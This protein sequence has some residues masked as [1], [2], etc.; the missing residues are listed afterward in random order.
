MPDDDRLRRLLVAVHAERR[1]F[2]REAVERLREVDLAVLVLRRDRE[3]DD[4]VGHEHRGH[5]DVDLAVGERV[6][7]GAVDAEHRDD[8]AAPAPRDVVHLVR[9]HAHEA[10]TLT[11]LLVRR[12]VDDEVALGDRALVDAH[13]RELTVAAVLELERRADERLVRRRSRARPSLR[14]CPDRA[15]VL[16]L[17]SGSAG[18]RRRRRAAA[19][20]PC[21]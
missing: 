9:V 15:P 17:A 13:V 21:S 1:V 20:R 4:R 5:R 16:D 14:S 12:A 19:A 10:R 7:R 11:F 8:V 18:S 6:A 3:R 2:L